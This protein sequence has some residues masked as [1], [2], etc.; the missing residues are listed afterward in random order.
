M[1]VI[2]SENEFIKNAAS[3][4][5]QI[6]DPINI[7]LVSNKINT[8]GEIVS[9]KLAVIVKDDTASISELECSLYMKVDS[10]IPYDLVLYTV[11]EW[12][13]LKNEIGTFAWKI[14]NTGAYLYGQRI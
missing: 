12:D 10:E 3:E 11:S 1:S 5:H 13:K 6:C 7:I 9:F 8:A 2:M 14:Y 4:I